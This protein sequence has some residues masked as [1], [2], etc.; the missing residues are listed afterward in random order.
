VLLVLPSF[1][2][3][4]PQTDPP[5]AYYERLVRRISLPPG[6]VLI[7]HRGLNLYYSWASGND[8]IS[9]V[10]ETPLPVERLWRVAAHVEWERL[11][12][13]L[14]EAVAAG[15]V[16]ALGGGYS[17]VRE[18]EWQRFLETIPAADRALYRNSWNPHERKP[19]FLRRQ[20]GELSAPHQHSGVD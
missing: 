18:D 7:C 10:P 1:S 9:F 16:R 5:Y 17:L 12:E 8:G 20:Q 4:R 6:T 15:R 2:A 3:Y 19:W 13:T 14:P 11:Q